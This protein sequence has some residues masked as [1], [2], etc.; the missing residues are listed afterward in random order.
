MH[1]FFNTVLVCLQLFA[2]W[3]ECWYS[4]LCEVQEKPLKYCSGRHVIRVAALCHLNHVTYHVFVRV[5]PI[6]PRVPPGP[7][8]VQTHVLENM[9]F[10]HYLPRLGVI[11]KGLS[12]Q[13]CICTRQT[14]SNCLQFC[15]AP[16]AKKATLSFQGVIESAEA[17]NYSQPMLVMRRAGV[18]LDC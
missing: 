12:C 13:S 1:S 3:Q 15:Q 14:C 4:V 17:P 8:M 9:K 18:E 2:H 7:S 5:G 16:L 10:G 6:E 11:S